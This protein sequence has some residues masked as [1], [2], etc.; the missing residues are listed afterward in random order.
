MVI[1]RRN[2]VVLGKKNLTH[3]C[4]HVTVYCRILTT[5][6]VNKLN[7]FLEYY[8]FNK[9]FKTCLYSET[10]SEYLLKIA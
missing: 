6:I 8:Y 9:L 5:L 2:A 3:V 1:D 7:V 10:I 4:M